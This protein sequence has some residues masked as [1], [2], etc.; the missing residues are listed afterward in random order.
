MMDSKLFQRFK[1][2]ITARF[3][4]P[5][6]QANGATNSHDFTRFEIAFEFNIQMQNAFEFNIQMYFA[7]EIAFESHGHPWTT[8]KLVWSPGR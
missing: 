8:R 7:F 4:D 6:S 3:A 1:I 2:D 5:S